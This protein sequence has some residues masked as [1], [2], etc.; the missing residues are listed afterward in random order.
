MDRV[1]EYVGPARLLALVGQMAPGVVVEVWDDVVRWCVADGVRR[2]TLTYVV[3]V[4]R[5]LLIADRH[6]EHV[7]CAG[8]GPVLC[9]GEL[10]V[11]LEGEDWVVEAVSNQSTGFCPSVDSWQVLDA[12]LRQLGCQYPD[13][14]TMACE[15]RR[16][17]VCDALALVK[18]GWYECVFCQAP[19]SGEYNVQ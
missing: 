4:R 6:C 12:V 2:Q 5:R 1:Y 8:G 11:A 18:E 3:D 15:F 14:W 10:T 13:G 16:C 17:D 7:V 19:L 9:A